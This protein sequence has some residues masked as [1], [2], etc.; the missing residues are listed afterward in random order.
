MSENHKFHNVP[1]GFIIRLMFDVFNNKGE[2]IGTESGYWGENDFGDND[3][4]PEIY[5]ATMYSTEKSAV[6]NFSIC[7]KDVI[8][9]FIRDSTVI[10]RQWN[11]FVH[12]EQVFTK[13]VCTD[14][15]DSIDINNAVKYKVG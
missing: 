3:I 1:Q 2:F 7:Y 14:Q 9:R 8:K 5:R 11:G 12:I 10:H 4:E 13:T 15:F 6:A